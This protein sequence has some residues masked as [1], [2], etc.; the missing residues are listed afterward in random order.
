MEEATSGRRME[1]RFGLPPLERLGWAA[2]I[3]GV[4]LLP[5]VLLLQRGRG[6][7][8]A[9]FQTLKYPFLSNAWVT[10]T[11]VRTSALTCLVCGPG[12]YFHLLFF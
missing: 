9:F 4:I 10:L 12:V 3:F 2:R 11:K 7:T 5:L 1:G 8:N 6:E